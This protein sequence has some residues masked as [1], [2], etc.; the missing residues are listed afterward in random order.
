[1]CV[2]AGSMGCRCGNSQVLYLECGSVEGRPSVIYTEEIL[3]GVHMHGF[4]CQDFCL[5][6]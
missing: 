4:I 5:N 2:M 6:I 1:M 3:E